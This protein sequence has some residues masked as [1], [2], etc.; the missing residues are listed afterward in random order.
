MGHIIKQSDPLHI[1]LKCDPQEAF[2]LRSI[3]KSIK[4][5]YHFNKDHW[6]SV[7]LDGSIPN[8]Q[9]K[10]MIKK[11]YEL[12]SGYKKVDISPGLIAPCG[13]NCSLCS[14]FQRVKNP[15]V[16]CNNSGNKPTYCIS[17]KIKICTEN[18]NEYCNMCEKHPCKRLKDLEKRYRTK[19]GVN[20]YENM[21]NI[22]EYGISVF[23][24]NEKKK[25]SCLKCG[26]ILSMHK[27]HCNE[28]KSINQN[29]LEKG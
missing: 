18:R 23:I 9:I 4:P 20:I 14:G 11:S 8:E 5:G 24:K 28:C 21:K 2:Y 17:C 1:I 27:E 25:W 26:S 6:N 16:G 12:V 13:I 10:Q 7:Y 22:L 15:C 19:Y 29:Y 3:F